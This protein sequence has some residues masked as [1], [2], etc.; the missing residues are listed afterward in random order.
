MCG[1][2]AANLAC[3]GGHAVH[4][5]GDAGAH[6]QQAVGIRVLKRG[7]HLVVQADEVRGIAQQGAACLGDFQALADALEQAGA[8]VLLQ[9]AD[10]HA[11][12][13]L[14]HIQRLARPW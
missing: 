14:R 7:L 9:L 1:K 13:G 3:Q 4:A 5:E 8:V 12:G 10:G 11:D 2:R 6:A